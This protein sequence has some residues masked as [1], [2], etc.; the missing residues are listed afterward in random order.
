MIESITQ[1]FVSLDPV[2]FYA[3]LFLSS[4]MENLFPPAPGDTITV[5]GAYIAGRSHHSLA[6]VLIATSL[7]GTA[8]FMTY[9]WLGRFIHPDYFERKNFRLFP[10]AGLRKARFW[11]Q[12]YGYW[13][14]V[15]NRFFSAIRGVISLVCGMYRL[16]WVRVLACS[17]IGCLIWNSMLI[18]AGYALGSN[19]Q[20]V[21]VIFRQY[22][23]VLAGVAAALL[24][25]WLLRRLSRRR[26]EPGG[27]R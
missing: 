17:A 14:V 27:S 2:W 13:L 5:F 15:T 1:Y 18:W 21:E 25:A 7:G 3:A 12:R 8:G 10:P 26:A 9:Y 6:G 4:Y 24:G 23:K 22:N 16:S 20:A 11:F 19:W